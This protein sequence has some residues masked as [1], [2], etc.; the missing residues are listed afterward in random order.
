MGRTDIVY[1]LL[2]GFVSLLLLIVTFSFPKASGGI[3]PRTYPQIVLAIMLALSVTL[4]AQGII[5]TRRDKKAASATLPRGK[6]AAKL[7]VLVAGCAAY[8]LLLEP[9][10]FII[11]TPLLT[12]LAMLLFGERRPLR[13]AL[14]SLTASVVLYFVFRGVFRVPLPR[15]FIW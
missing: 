2:L 1:G 5:H 4:T 13:I 3:N 10:G 6:T 7:L 11:A 9:V 8:A 14:V 15:S 12:V